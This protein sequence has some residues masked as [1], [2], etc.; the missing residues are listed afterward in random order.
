MYVLPDELKD[1]LKEPI[2]QLVDEQEL[3][4]IIKKREI[5]CFCWGSGYLHAFKTWYF[6]YFLCC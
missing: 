5:H 1:T 2:G 3:L 6:S 4:K